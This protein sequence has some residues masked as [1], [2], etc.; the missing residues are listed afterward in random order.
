MTAN[1]G[2]KRHMDGKSLF[3][4]VLARFKPGWE[5]EWRSLAQLTNGIT[6]TDPRFESVCEALERCD[7]TFLANDWSRFREA[8]EEVERLVKERQ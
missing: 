7:H 3:E 4:K 1:T 6:K 2:G 8:A 5:K